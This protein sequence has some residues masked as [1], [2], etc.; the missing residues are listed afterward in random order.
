MTP[1]VSLEHCPV[2]GSFSS[3]PDTLEISLLPPL[4]AAVAPCL[5][6][7]PSGCFRYLSTFSGKRNV[8][9]CPVFLLSPLHFKRMRMSPPCEGRLSQSAAQ[10]WINR[11]RQCLVPS[12]EKHPLGFT[13]NINTAVQA[14][15]GKELTVAAFACCKHSRSVCLCVCV[16]GWSSACKL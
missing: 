14:E 9:L 13:A 1:N 2:S 3:G 5:I 16:H 6:L 10:K 7:S 4:L 12:C 11:P 15:G 8:Q